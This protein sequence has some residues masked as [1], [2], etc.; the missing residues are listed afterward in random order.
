MLARQ[1]DPRGPRT[2]L[3]SWP[4][5]CIVE[6]NG[7]QTGGP[8]AVRGVDEEAARETCEAKARKIRTDAREDLVARL[9]AYSWL[10]HWGMACTMIM[11]CDGGIIMPSPAMHVMSMCSFLLNGPG[12]RDHLP[13]NFFVGSTL[14]MNTPMGTG[15]S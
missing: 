12:L 1:V 5:W 2:G 15:V 10:N 4:D 3:E 14:A 13:K 11:S 7:R 9:R 8:H 6:R